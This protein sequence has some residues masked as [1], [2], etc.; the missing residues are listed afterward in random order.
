V[1]T[2]VRAL[3]ASVRSLAPV[4][5]E[6]A[7]VL[8]VSEHDR[9]ADRLH[10]DLA[11]DG[12]A[13][14]RDRSGDTAYDEAQIG[15]VHVVI[16]DM[17]LRGQPGLAVCGAVR[18]RS[19]VPILALG[20]RTEE[21][22]VLAV[23]A[24][25]A[26][27]YVTADTSSRLVVARLRALLRRVP[28]RHEPVLATRLGAAVVIDESNGSVVVAGDVVRLSRRELEVLRSLLARPGCVVT[29]T[30]LAGSWPALSA[31]RRLDFVI[32]RLRQKLEAVDGRRRISAVR[33]VGFRFEEDALDEVTAA[34]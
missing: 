4:G 20:D 32:R 9:W 1:S 31:D 13:V 25:G 34:P 8:L 6:V 15:P 33:G 29:R 11:A 19:T 28:P 3:A 2:A 12:F 5:S 17:R 16:I 23:Y 24:A 7:R 10:A 14:H 26:D 21:Q 22:A 27:Q 30:E 18:A